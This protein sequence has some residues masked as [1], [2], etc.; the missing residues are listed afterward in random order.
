MPQ[1]HVKPTPPKIDTAKLSATLNN[2]LVIRLVIASVVFALSLIVDMP[3][4]AGIL[5]LV[6]ASV[7]AGY[8]IIMKAVEAVEGGDFTATPV[9]V[10]V[11]A[12]LAFFIGFG[13]EGAA[14][15]LLYQIGM[16]LLKYVQEHTRKAALDLIQDQDAG[17]DAHSLKFRD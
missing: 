10:V 3:D 15:V 9:I 13:I 2:S 12:V 6:L 8:D 14:L 5:L 11:T 17:I 7:L 4:F 1:K 16:L